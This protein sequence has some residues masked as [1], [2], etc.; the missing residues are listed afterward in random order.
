LADLYVRVPV[1]GQANARYMVGLLPCFAVLAAAR[2]APLVRFRL[3]RPVVF[4]AIV[5]GAI[6]AYV[7]YFDLEAIRRLFGAAS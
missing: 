5:C 7:A 4:A 2:A 3:L 1:Y 6:A